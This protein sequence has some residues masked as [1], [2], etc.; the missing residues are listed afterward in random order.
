M[1]KRVADRILVGLRVVKTV[2]WRIVDACLCLCRTMRI[3]LLRLFLGDSAESCAT[4]SQAPGA[5]VSIEKRVSA[6]GILFDSTLTLRI[7]RAPCSPFP[8]IS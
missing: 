2:H 7:F 1:L 6:V 4:L 5:P 3:D 8:L